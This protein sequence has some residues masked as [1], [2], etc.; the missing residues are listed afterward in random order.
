[1]SLVLTLVLL[2]SLVIAAN[3]TGT[4][5]TA[6]DGDGL[7][8]DTA[9][10]GG[11]LIVENIANGVLRVRHDQRDTPRPWFNWAFRL[12]GQA[13]R[14]VEVQFGSAVVGVRGPA[15]S[16]DDGATWHWLDDT[17]G[18][19]RSSF[20]VTLPADGSAL[21]LSMGIPYQVSTWTA[22][23]TA[24]PEL[25]PTSLCQS[26]HGR[27]VPLLRV[28]GGTSAP[29]LIVVTARHHSCEAMAGFV[30]EG[31]ARA[32]LAD[33]TWKTRA[34]CVFIPFV[35]IDGVEEGDQGKGRQPHDHGRDYHGDS[36]YPETAAIR[37]GLPTWA[38]GRRT[39]VIDLHC[40][41][42]GG[43]HHQHIH[44]V[45]AADATA[46]AAQQR[47]AEVLEQTKR[48]PLP[49]RATGDLPFGSAWNVAASYVDG[50]SLREWASEQ[51]HMRLATSIEIPYADANSVAV[52]PDGARAFGAD[53]AR[54]LAALLAR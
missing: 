11:N 29:C 16:G 26:R 27:Q 6:W 40:P 8:V 17:A 52:L 7:S 51:P 14:R 2:P 53:L 10:P 24:N 13:G 46:W 9:F 35:D 37:V 49:Y 31:L 38:A 32:V 30:L 19:R 1:M 23:T 5:Q 45:G 15:L 54:A 25:K 39:I 20:A 44:Q 22:F 21:R 41:G 47:F 4:P 12:R 43:T 42:L 18:A 48:G 36:L 50:K 33:A 28:G 3:A 34:E